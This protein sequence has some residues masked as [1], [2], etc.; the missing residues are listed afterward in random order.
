MSSKG[1]ILISQERVGKKGVIFQCY[2][3]RTM[4]ENADDRLRELLEKDLQTKEYWEKFRKLKNDPRVTTIGRFLRK[5][6]LD[7]LPQIINIIKGEMSFVG[8][9]PAFQEEMDTFSKDHY[10]YK[11]VKPGITGLWQVCRTRHPTKDFQEWIHYDA[12]YVKNLS[13]R[14]DLWIFWQTIKN[15]VKNFIRQF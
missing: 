5:T 13:L 6:S 1:P 2:K 10:Y 7:E 12:K 11:S 3:F 8:P 4:Y 14:M 9:R 15:L